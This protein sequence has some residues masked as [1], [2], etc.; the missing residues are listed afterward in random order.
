MIY[1]KFLEQFTDWRPTT[2]YWQRFSIAE[3]FGKEEI[4]TVYLEVFKEAKTNYK[5]LTELAMILNHKSWEHCCYNN[6]SDLCTFYTNLYIEVK[7]YAC[8]AL[9]DDEL[10]YFL[11]T[12]D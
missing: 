8:D 7:N 2:L 5:L 1:E 12:L 6:D 11:T 4:L 9:K 3:K 10:T